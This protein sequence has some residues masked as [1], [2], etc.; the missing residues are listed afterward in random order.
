MRALARAV[1]L[2]AFMVGALAAV[3]ATAVPQAYAAAE[4]ATALERAQ[5]LYDRGRYEE[6]VTLLKEHIKTTPDP[7]AYFLIAYSLYKLQRHDEASEYFRQAYLVKPDYSPTPEIEQ[8]QGRPFED[9]RPAGHTGTA[10]SGTA[11]TTFSDSVAPTM[12]AAER[13]QEMSAAPDAPAAPAPAPATDQEA[14]P[15][16]VGAESATGNQ[17]NVADLPPAPEPPV[18][19]APPVVEEVPTPE[20]KPRPVPKLPAKQP[21]ADIVTMLIAMAVPIGIGLAVF[22]LLVGLPI[23]LIAKKLGVDKPWLG[24]IPIVQLVPL[25]KSAGKPAWWMLLFFVPVV[26]MFISL[27]VF[28]LIAENL[29]RSKWLGLVLG[30]FLGPIGLL[31]LALMG[32][33]GAAAAKAAAG[34]G[35]M[36]D[37][38]GDPD[39]DL[40][41]VPMDEMGGGDEPF[42]SDFGADDSAGAA[43]GSD[44]FGADDFGGGDAGGTEDAADDFSDFGGGGDDDAGGFDF[45]TD[46]GFEADGEDE[47]KDSF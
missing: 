47:D 23:F 9:A 3:S 17:A 11:P 40:P 8:Q 22:V 20:P 41:D 45:D 38:G 13:R 25:V 24:F 15:P 46:T 21:E 26:G 2:G 7:K 12:G 31:I 35:D 36:L 4:Q 10:Q 18:V 32:R 14:F 44:D 27:Y 29:G 28:M 33:G 42:G 39:L 16:I 1:L 37:F 19:E 5:S 43:Y 34:G 30:L 6:A